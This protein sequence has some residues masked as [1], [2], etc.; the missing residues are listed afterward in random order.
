MSYILNVLIPWGKRLHLTGSDCIY[1]QA[2]VMFVWLT[3]A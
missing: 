2:F 1:L 3:V